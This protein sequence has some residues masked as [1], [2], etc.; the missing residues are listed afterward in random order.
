MPN[1]A[2]ETRGYVLITKRLLEIFQVVRERIAVVSRRDGVGG[3][4]SFGLG[5]GAR[6]G[7]Q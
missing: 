4:R 1:S 3:A 6:R 5:D 7:S 2:E